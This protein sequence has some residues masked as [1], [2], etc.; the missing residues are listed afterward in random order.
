MRAPII[1]AIGLVPIVGLVAHLVSFPQA[2][3]YRTAAVERGSLELTVSAN[4]TIKPVKTVD[5]SSQ[6]SGQ[7]AELLV[8][9]NDDVQ[10]EQPIAR[11]DSR[12]FAA[13]VRAARSALEVAK[14]GVKTKQAALKV[15]E[16]DLQNARA[17]QFVLEAQVESTEA[18]SAQAGRDLAR[19]S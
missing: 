2:V 9:F 1:M 6:L 16:A 7:V 11:L 10:E 8:D 4:G 18:T 13:K 12:S 14:I 5:V 17:S 3:T 15:A 19:K